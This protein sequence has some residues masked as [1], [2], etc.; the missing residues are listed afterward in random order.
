MEERQYVNLLRKMDHPGN[1]IHHNV[2]IWNLY[3]ITDR[4]KDKGNIGTH[5]PAEVLK[6]I[7]VKKSVF[8]LSLL[9][10]IASTIFIQCL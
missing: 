6:G 3:E 7:N 5:R 4:V 2:D 1:K 9:F 8:Q 10:L